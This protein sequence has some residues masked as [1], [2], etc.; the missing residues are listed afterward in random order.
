MIYSDA[1]AIVVIIKEVISQINHPKRGR[2]TSN[3]KI[4]KALQILGFND[5]QIKLIQDRW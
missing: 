5:T 4:E 2:R 1:D 3:C